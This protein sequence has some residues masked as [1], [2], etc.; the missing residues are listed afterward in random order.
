MTWQRSCVEIF[1]VTRPSWNVVAGHETDACRIE[2]LGSEDRS[3][4]H[5]TAPL[6]LCSA[7]VSGTSMAMLFPLLFLC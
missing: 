5:D 1:Q 7:N 2:R 3:N 6:S 4:F